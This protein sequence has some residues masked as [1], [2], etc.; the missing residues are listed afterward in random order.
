MATPL[1]PSGLQVTNIGDTGWLAVMNYNIA[2]LHATLLKLSAMGDVNVVGLVNGD[3]LRWNASTGKW[4]R[5]AVGHAPYATTTS[6][7]TSSTSSTTSSTT[8][9]PAGMITVSSLAY[10]WARGGVYQ[11]AP[12]SYGTLTFATPA[13]GADY[14]E[15]RGGAGV[16]VQRVVMNTNYLKLVDLDVY[17]TEA[18]TSRPALVDLAASVGYLTMSDCT[19]RRPGATYKGRGIYA[20]KGGNHHITLTDCSI[21]DLWGPFY[22][23]IGDSDLL[24]DRCTF[25]RNNSD[26][27]EHSEGIDLNRTE[28]VVIRNCWFE[29][30]E[31]TA[32]IV[33]LHY[34]AKRWKIYNNIFKMT[35]GGTG[36]TGHGTISDNTTSTA[37]SEDIEIYHNTFVNV[38]SYSGRS[39]V[40]F[41]FPDNVIAKNNLFYNCA[42][43]AMLGVTDD[44]TA[45]YDCPASS[46]YTPAAHDVS[47]VGD[48]FADADYRL[49]VANKHN[50]T[51]LS[52]EFNTDRD[53]NPRTHWHMGAYE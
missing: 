11:L 2:R 19:V 40:T 51:P 43:I 6:T 48:P 9:P 28:D 38:G 27:S 7:T 45:T 10:P 52:A 46:E 35:L 22:Y 32:V 17:N 39:G 21:R 4:V 12:G 16:T 26:A 53:G 30:V 14:V 31:G 15:I 23:G 41:W 44:Y 37:N 1:T 13:S 5:H 3:I 47:G 18:A 8:E 50:G 20:T 34:G 33:A 25:L 49:N 42:G 36:S 29:D 24:F